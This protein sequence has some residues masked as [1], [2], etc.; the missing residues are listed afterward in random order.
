V[1]SVK[2]ALL[3]FVEPW[4]ARFPEGRVVSVARESAD[5]LRRQHNL[6]A[7]S[8]IGTSLRTGGRPPARIAERE[9]IS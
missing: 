1:R 7:L 3:E 6:P 4:I 2:R 5:N 8:G 9:G